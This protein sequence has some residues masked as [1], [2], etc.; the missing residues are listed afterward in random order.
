M[1]DIMDR[2]K[3]APFIKVRFI[4]VVLA[5]LCPVVCYIARQNLP[6][7]I[8]AMIEDSPQKSSAGADTTPANN[9]NTLTAATLLVGSSSE[10]DHLA[11]GQC[12]RPIEVD[13]DGQQHSMGAAQSHGPKYAWTKEERAYV[14][15]A[16]FYTYVIFMIPAGRFAEIIGAKWVMAAAGIGSCLLSLA[17]PFAAATHV[18]LFIL[19]R[20]LMG[21]CQTALY[22]A[23]YVLYTKWLPPAERSMALPILVVGA[24]IGAIVTSTVTGYFI[25][26]EC[27]GWPYAFYL[28]ALLCACWSILW[29]IF[30]T[31]EPRQHKSMSLEELEYIELKTGVSQATLSKKKKVPSWAKISTSRH[32]WVMVAAFVASN[33]AFSSTLLLLPSYLDQI[34]LIPPFRNGLVNSLVSLLFCIASPIVGALATLMV[35]TRPC[36]ISHLQIRK[37]FQCTALFSQAV[38]FVLLP[39]IGCNTDLALYLL[40]VQ[41]VMFSFVNG[42]EVQLPSDL[43]VDFAG[44]IYAIGNCIGSSTGFLVPIIHAL[45]VSD[46][47]DREQWNRYFYSAAIITSVGGLIFMLFGRNDLQDFAKSGQGDDVEGD[48]NVRTEDERDV[49]RFSTDNS[50]KLD[51]Q[52]VKQK[53]ITI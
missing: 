21:A 9:N 35:E 2:Q 1:L 24:F 15:G 49:G 4:V 41:I 46:S 52:K 44:T 5:T 34:L 13:S 20:A 28:P 45:I 39:A 27:F 29:L 53:Q 50:I 30:V 6:M 10:Q 11:T 7:A 22:P 3:K 51:A 40:Y 17:S 19:V 18:W 42:G 33:W 32:V 12:P 48:E 38:C 25:E 26:K 47:K 16:F 23:G 31:S 8:N 14:L 36:R 43:S 37:L